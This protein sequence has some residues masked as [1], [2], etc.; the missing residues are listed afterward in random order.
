MLFELVDKL[1]RMSSKCQLHAPNVAI[2]IAK[3]QCLLPRSHHSIEYTLP[4]FV[5]MAI[6]FSLMIT[7][8][9]VHCSCDRQEY[10]ICELAEV[11]HVRFGELSLALKVSNASQSAAPDEPE[12]RDVSDK[13][14]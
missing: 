4:G 14:R 1:S 11:R 8:A 3:V 10:R 6:S 7:L 12:S 9:R 2:S 5:G 13:E